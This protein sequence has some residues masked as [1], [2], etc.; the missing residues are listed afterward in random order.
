MTNVFRLL[1]NYF[2]N[3]LGSL[4][5]K[6]K[7]PKFYFAILICVIIS[8]SSIAMFTINS[9]ASI[10]LYL[11]QEVDNPELL[12]MFSTTTLALM[13]LLFVTIMRSVYPSKSSDHDFLLSLPVRKIDIVLAKAIY[14]YLFDLIIFISI[15]LPGYIVFYV[16][17]PNSS[18][19][20]VT[21]SSLFILIL[22][23]IS[24][25]L[26]T[27]V[28]ILSDKLSRMFKH[29]SIIQTIIMILLVGL[30][31]VLNY[32]LQGYLMNATGSAEDVINSIYVIKV[33]LH[34]VL[35]GNTI[36][37]IIIL[38]FSL[39]CYISSIVYLKSQL[40]K[41]K[42]EKIVVNK[43]L[44]FK[45]NMPIVALTKKE[46]KQYFHIPVYLMNTIIPCVLYFGL[47]VAISVLGKEMALSFVALLP[48]EL[49]SNF[50]VFLLMILSILISSFVIT[51]SSIS[52]EG[53]HF[54]IVRT[55][56][57][58]N[59]T[60]FKSKI[61]ANL[62]ISSIVILISF[63]FVLTFVEIQNCWWFIIIPFL[64]SFMSSTLGLVVNLNFPKMEWE[65]EEAVV[66]QS[67]SSLISMF[68]PMILTIIPF[69]VYLM[70]FSTVISPIIF[71][72]LLILYFILIIIL[73]FYWLK[74]KGNNAL[75]DTCCK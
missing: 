22:P 74:N 68:F 10:K 61:Y 55:N 32:S 49:V 67:M 59:M 41:L 29:Y 5:K 44:L 9:I 50:D 6:Q 1:K 31:L 43:E 33:V 71:I 47:S 66:K 35:Y 54:W 8:L 53:K 45:V 34:F 18:F 57:I 60:L 19:W 37:F 12:S 23:L 62:V 69:I 39:I 7:T 51:G 21:R 28:G 40:G 38:S 48:K 56:A 64:I 36:N 70:S 13:M 58:G 30:Y 63:P 65:K 2:L 75:Y 11:E 16:M 26:A 42:K 20:V 25:A 73:L 3:F 14:N 46:L 17:V 52:L 27:F 4:I 24:N 15:L 72:L